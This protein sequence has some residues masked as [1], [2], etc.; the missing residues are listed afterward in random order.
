MRYVMCTRS[1]GACLCVHGVSQ[2]IEQNWQ[3]EKYQIV[4]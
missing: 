1:G 4:Y 3:K 2:K